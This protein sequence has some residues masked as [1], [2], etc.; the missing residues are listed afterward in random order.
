VA[1][2]VVD[3]SSHFRFSVGDYIED[4]LVLIPV[5]LL[6]CFIGSIG[7]AIRVTKSQAASVGSGAFAYA[8]GV[9]LIGYVVDG[10]NIHGSGGLA[11][12][13]SLPMFLLA[14]ILWALAM[15]KRRTN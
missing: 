9:I 5:G 1:L 13:L 6:L 8:C 10:M 4:T 3:L 2:A 11:M 14:L 7:W 15:F 12:L